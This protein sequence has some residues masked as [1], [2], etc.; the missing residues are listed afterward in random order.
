[1]YFC[2]QIRG[3]KTPMKQ[4]KCHQEALTF[5]IDVFHN[6]IKISHLRISLHLLIEFLS[7]HDKYIRLRFEIFFFSA[8]I[9][10]A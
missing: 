3:V 9:L 1:M 2:R 10:L 7:E 5:S 6:R 4:K 8:S